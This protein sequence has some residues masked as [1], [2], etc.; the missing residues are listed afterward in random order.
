MARVEAG[1]AEIAVQ[2]EDLG[3]GALQDAGQDLLVLA[4]FVFR[5]P[6]E[7][8]AGPAFQ[9]AQAE[10]RGQDGHQDDGTHQ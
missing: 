4:D 8:D 10:A 7:L 5:T 9:P 6:V 2:R 1:V 3:F